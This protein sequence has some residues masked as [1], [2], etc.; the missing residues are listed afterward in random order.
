MPS[1]PSA[2]TVRHTLRHRFGIRRL[3]EGQQAVIARVFEGRDTLAVMPTGAGKSLCYQLPAA[4][5]P[6]LVVVVSPLISLMKDQ[7]EKLGPAGIDA[8]QFNSAQPDDE[9]DDALRRIGGASSG[10]VFTTPERLAQ[11]TFIAALRERPI[12]LLVVDEAH[13][14]AQWGHDFR[15]AF[16]EIDDALA[17]LNRPPVLALTATATAEVIDD[18]RHQ[19]HRPGMAVVNTGIY[20]SNLD[21]AVRQITREDEKF[22][23]LLEQVRGTAGSGIVYTATVK[24][25]TEVY[26]RL[27]A[28]GESADRYHGKLAAAERHASQDRFM[29][30]QTRVMVATSAFGMGIDKADVRFVVHYQMPGTLEAYYQEAGRAGRDGAASTCSLLF[31]RKDRQVQQFFLSRRY[32]SADDLAR[33]HAA[34]LEAAGPSSIAALEARLGGLPRGRVA[35]ALSLLRDGKLVRSNRSREWV[36]RAGDRDVSATLETLAQAYVDKAERDRE[37]LE[38]MVFYAQT[39]WCRWRVLLEHFGES[40]SFENGCGACDNCRRPRLLPESEPSVSSADVLADPTPILP[41]GAGDDVQVPRYG[42]GRVLQIAGEEVT[43]G[44]PDGVRRSFLAAY[45]QKAGLV[46]AQTDAEPAAATRR[47]RPRG[48]AVARPG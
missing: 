35:V 19:L 48:A 33:V 22:E 16:L 23:A 28:A 21:F 40:L 26:E 18:I 5:L 8:Y 45:V 43:V 6:G 14:I 1:V 7:A 3:T 15:P 31:D 13:C 2:A 4:H 41:F 36:L 12:A 10:V 11:S 17:A 42:S 47:K 38:R 32:P 46:I 25:C 37:S 24:A 39:G 9:Q 30:G 29:E 20:R 44:F 27:I 34:L